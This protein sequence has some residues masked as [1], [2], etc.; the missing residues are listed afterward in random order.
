[1]ENISPL[2]GVLLLSF[3]GSIAGLIGGVIF[4]VKKSWARSLGKYAVPFA[5]GVML[6]VA[7]LDLM[8]ESVE[9]IGESAFVIV[10]ISLLGSFFFEQFFA[11][12]HHHDERGHTMH[13]TSIPLVVFGD[14]IHNFIDGVA[15]ASAY[16]TNPFFGVVIAF[17][18]FLHETPHEIG[19]FGILY[20]GGWSRLKTFCVNLFSAAFTFPGALFVFFFARH[21]PGLVGVLLAISAGV[22]LY[23][24]ASDFLPEVGEHDH[25][26]SA[27]KKFAL[28][29]AGV[30]LMYIV[31][32]V[33]PHAR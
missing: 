8:P 28:L 14:S 22:F 7:L 3:V 32:A 20:S 24:G 17:A 23:L 18:T 25:A 19:D 4:L 6:S 12:L 21:T 29:L 1:M 2:V 31:T 10:L 30:V 16:L 5:A 11:H 13:K 9:E 15:I 26:V 27:R 33:S